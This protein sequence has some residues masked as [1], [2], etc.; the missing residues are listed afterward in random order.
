MNSSLLLLLQKAYATGWLVAAP[1]GPVNLEII[2]RSLRYRLL[3]GFLVGC[4]ACCVDATYLFLFSAGM[5]E[6]LRLPFVRALA[7]LLGGGFLAW[8]GILALLDARKFA[9]QIPNSK[10]VDRGQIA[11][12]PL[13]QTA[14]ANPEKAPKNPKE[15]DARENPEGRAGGAP[16]QTRSPLLKCYLV[17]IGMTATNPMTIA[18][19]SALSL[20]FANLNLGHRLAASASVLAGA[21]SWILL[22]MTMLAFVRRWVGPRLFAIVNLAGGAVVLYFGMRFLWQ[23]SGLEVWL[24]SRL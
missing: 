15:S 8:L 16:A 6:I 24:S 21:M 23:G 1:I 10:S 7:F 2:R 4:G 14:G 18:F 5:V 9:R 13:P 17:G 20:G 11:R 22:L 19:W 12:T 3:A